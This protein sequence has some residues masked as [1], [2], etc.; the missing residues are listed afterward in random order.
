MRDAHYLDPFVRS[1]LVRADDLADFGIEDLGR[2]ARQGCE[3][4][5]FQP[6]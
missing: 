1:H 5:R 6:D 2:G 3:A 4:G